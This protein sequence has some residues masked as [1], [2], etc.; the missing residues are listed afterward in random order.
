[1]GIL[2]GIL[3]GYTSAV[4]GPDPM[5]TANAYNKLQSE[6]NTRYDTDK[7]KFEADP[8]NTGKAYALPD[9]LQ[10]WQDQVNG[11][12]TSG[13]PTLMKE[14]LAQ[15]SQYNQRAT[16][17]MSGSDAPSAV[18]EWQALR[19]QGDDISLKD[20][21]REKQSRG[22]TT[23]KVQVGQA[24]KEIPYTDLKNFVWPD[25]SPVMP[26]TTGQQLIDGGARP[27]QSEQQRVAGAGG[28]VLEQSTE[29]MTDTAAAAVGTPAENVLNELRTRP[30]LIGELAD[31][32]LNLAGVPM[33]EAPA[34]FINYRASVVQQT[35][36]L[37]SGASATDQEK[38]DYQR[39][40]PKLTEPLD[41]QLIKIKQANDF[42]D[43]II[44]RNIAAGIAP[45]SARRGYKAKESDKV[46]KGTDTAVGNAT[47]PAAA[48]AQKPINWADLK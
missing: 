5:D 38:S 3:K 44:E 30:G 36:K 15:L 25:G 21:L 34:K 43:A 6:L 13:D 2:D 48:S 12:I 40:L 39:M 33:K 23:V 46:S 14:G 41:V 45:A 37:M 1:M 16:Q 35:V 28:D 8:A 22:G 10:R 19:A 11:M 32:G 31:M 42:A 27:I 47:Q 20:Y 9:P 29:G 18:K 26:G 4:L 7:Q 17:P 24:A